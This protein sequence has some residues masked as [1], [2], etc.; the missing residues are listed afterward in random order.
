MAQETIDLL[1]IGGGINGAGIARDAAGRDLA[2]LV[3]EQGDLGGATS[4]ASSKLIHGGLRYLEKYAF[5]LVKEA[6]SEREVLLKSAPHLIFPLDF[7]LPCARNTRSA[8]MLGLGLWLYDHLGGAHQFSAS[9][10]IDLHQSE[11]GKALKR[12]LAHGFAYSDCRVDD[13]RLVIANMLGAHKLGA[14]VRP[15][16]RCLSARRDGKFWLATLGQG[17]EYIE[18]R[19][20]ALI[21][22]AGPWVRS[23]FDDVIQQRTKHNVRLVKGSHIVIPR[24]YSGEHAYL[25]QNYD[26]RVVFAIPF[27]DR[28]TLIGT[29]DISFQGDP[30]TVSASNSE[31]EY[32]CEA[33]NRYFRDAVYPSEVVWH[34]S[35]V[36]ALYDDGRANPS[37]VSRDYRLILETDDMQRLPVLSVYGGKITTYR[38]LAEAALKNLEPWLLP[39]KSSWTAH[40]P[41]PGGNIPGADFES[42]MAG[43]EENYP[44]LPR[45]FLRELA[46]R[47]GSLIEDV[48][49]DA[50]DTPELGEN[51][52]AGLFAREVDYFIEHEWA[53]SAEDI[54]WRRSKTGLFLGNAQKQALERYVFNKLAGIGFH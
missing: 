53:R 30:A 2:V 17:N 18:V 31:I 27:Q 16:T 1:I 44:K 33:V 49:G 40:Q 8:W 23:L 6:L 47:H 14:R 12:E 4:S 5:R 10:A 37:D 36:R 54:L 46:S 24:R 22:A 45:T 21:N 13:A 34:Y 41:L 20:K 32:L 29:T 19:A 52:G 7:V 11:Y 25:L 3:C 38:K 28:F 43:L 35:G 15:R 42:F 9:R 51:F 39:A 48:L 26:Q 50:H